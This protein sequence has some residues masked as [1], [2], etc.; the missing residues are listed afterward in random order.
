[1]IF[2]TVGTILPFDRLTRALDAWAETR[3][4][5]DIFGQLGDLGPENYRPRHFEWAE[6]LTPSDFRAR[7][8]EADLIAGHAGIG[9]ITEALTRG[10]PLLIMPRR[11]ALREHVNDHQLETV[12]KF[13][14]RPGIKV[15]MTPEEIPEALDAILAADNTAPPL[16]AY[17]E[18]SLI[19][20]VRAA[21]FDTR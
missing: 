12:A 14:E 3:G 10:K 9:T 1:M 15:V 17:A 21:I 13:G 4:R 8:E 18:Q 19:D 7:I 11:H 16:S 6:R 20:A 2:M 5:Q